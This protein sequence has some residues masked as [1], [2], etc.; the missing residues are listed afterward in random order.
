MSQRN[1]I[2]RACAALLDAS[3]QIDD[4]AKADIW[5]DLA[6]DARAQFDRLT[7]ER[8]MF[9]RRLVECHPWVGVC[10]LAADRIQEVCAV[11]DLA[12]DALK[13]VPE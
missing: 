5:R 12:D 10:P 1:A 7:H 2:L 8:R 9:R 6:A 13:E 4:T 11:R 3:Y